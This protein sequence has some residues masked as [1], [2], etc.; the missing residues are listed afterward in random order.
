MFG[1]VMGFMCG[2]LGDIIQYIIKPTGPYFP[3]WT[4][5]AALLGL[6]MVYFSMTATSKFPRKK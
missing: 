5:S 4:L 2:G 6:S 3:G 1:P